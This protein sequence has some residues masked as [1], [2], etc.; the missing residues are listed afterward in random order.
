MARAKIIV[1]PKKIV[2]R[3]ARKQ[4]R[5]TTDTDYLLKDNI[6]KYHNDLTNEL[7]FKKSRKK[8]EHPKRKK[9]RK[10]SR[11]RKK[12]KKEKR[13]IIKAEPVNKVDYGDYEPTVSIFDE[14]EDSIMNIPD[15]VYTWRKG[16][17]GFIVHDLSSFKMGVVSLVRDLSV[18][19]ATE[20]KEYFI[21]NE[22]AIK[23]E[24]DGFNHVSNDEQLYTSKNRLLTLL[25]FGYAPSAEILDY[26]ELFE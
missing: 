26:L 18:N 23:E 19:D 22:D 1:R 7:P 5:V 10:K 17:K 8:Q 16:K 20:I 12:L 11:E 4:S 3:K 15:E 13:K 24:I 25:N 14:I 6:N 21:N 2:S 9:D